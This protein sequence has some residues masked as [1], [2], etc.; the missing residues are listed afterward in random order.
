MI[1]KF[2]FKESVMKIQ[3]LLILLGILLGGML[4]SAQ[5]LGDQD[6]VGRPYMI[7]TMKNKEQVKLEYNEA[8]IPWV[9]TEIRDELNCDTV[10]QFDL[11]DVE[12]VIVLNE[13]W[14]TCDHRDEWLFDVYFKDG[15]PAL[16][17]FMEVQRT[18]VSSRAFAA[19]GDQLSAPLRVVDLTEIDKISFYRGQE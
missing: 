4:L 3:H 2:G 10:V 6:N 9:S 13:G 5:Q 14:N 11:A 7:M 19:D 1:Q 17:G 18:Q 16:R 12:E 15:R 8:I